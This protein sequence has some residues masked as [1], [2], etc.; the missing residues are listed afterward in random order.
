MLQLYHVTCILIRK[1]LDLYRR[2]FMTR[3]FALAITVL[4]ASFTALP[5]QAGLV[6]GSFE[7]PVVPVGSFSDF[8]NGSIG[9]T[10]W[11]VVGGS[12]VAIVSGSLNAECCTFPAQ[13][14][15][16]WLDLTGLATGATAGVEQTSATVVGTSY[17]LTFFVGNVFDPA[18]VFGTTSTVKVLLGGV[19]GTSLGTFTNSSTTPGTQVWQQFSTVFTATAAN[20]TLDFVSQDPAGDN[21]NGLDNVVLTANVV[22]SVPEPGTMML[23]GLSLAGLGTWKRFGQKSA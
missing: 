7:T 14:G 2:N 10:G 12:D 1:D 20:T 5:L 15:A 6:N 18:G 3:N 4:V 16:Q 22:S 9:I 21:S 17:T 13:N 11:T 19:S 23:L 8:A